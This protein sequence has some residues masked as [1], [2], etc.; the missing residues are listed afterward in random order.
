MALSVRIRKFERGLRFRHGD[1]AGLVMPGRRWLWSRL[2]TQRRDSIAV[3]NTLV[4]QLEVPMLDVIVRHPSMAEAVEVV[5]L[6]ESQRALVWVDGRLFG[7]FGPGK[8][9]FWKQPR[10]LEVE[11]FDV[12]TLRFEHPFIEAVM[13]HPDAPKHL[14][15]IEVAADHDVLLFRNGV[16]VGKMTPGKHV[17]WKGAGRLLVKAIDRRE[18]T[19]DVAGQEIMTAD[20]V[21]LR[22]NLVVTW[23][24]IDAV[25]SATVVA[26]AAQSLYREAQ[27]AL[28]AAVGTR[29]L[30]QLLADKESIGGEVRSSLMA[31]AD[32]FGVSVRSV[33]LRDIIL[34]GEMKTI[35]NRVIEAEKQ[36]Q[37][38]L[39]RRREETAAAR[40]QA[41]TAR[42][43]AENPTLARM[44][45]L[46]LLQSVLAG[47]KATFVFA[48][49]QG[50]ES[51]DL[52][53]QLRSLIAR[54]DGPDSPSRGESGG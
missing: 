49:G 20:K 37:A 50:K 1:F 29:T 34:P 11:V 48:S 35:L 4:P 51:G 16:L 41:N 13:A 2:F 22:V 32:E 47:T 26:D 31:R 54:E 9:A 19:A 14:Q 7:L 5:D 8:Y 23:Q 33:G 39:I 27:L 46:E 52:L 38:D 43:L 18:Q 40:S 6:T 53:Q 17:F 45:E 15:E 36:A 30:D 44:K 28:R 25:K 42:L 12:S 3:V 10:R 24:V 21:T